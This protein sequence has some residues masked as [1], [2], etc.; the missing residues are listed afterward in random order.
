[1]KLLVDN[2]T[3]ILNN[4]YFQTLCLL[5]YPGEKFPTLSDDSSN[6]AFFKLEE[7][8]SDNII[9]YMATVRL[10]AGLRYREAQF[11]SLDY[12]AVIDGDNEFFATLALGKAFLEAGK[13]L[14]GFSMPWGYIIGLRPVKRARYYLEHGYDADTVKRF[15]IDDYGVLEQK[16]ELSVNT[17]LLEIQMLSGVKNNTCGLYISIPFCPTRCSYC[18]FVSY[19]N[20]KLFQLIPDYLEKLKRDLK[21]T[22]ALLKELNFSLGT[23]Y[24]GGGTPSILDC[25]QLEDLLGTV[26]KSFNLNNLKEYSFEAGRPDTITADKLTVIKSHGVNRISI[27]PQTTNENVLQRI[28]RCHTVSQFFNSAELAKKIGFNCI[29]ADLIAGLPDDT[30]ENFAKSLSD[31][32]SLNFENITVHTLSIKNAA[33]LRFDPDKLYDPA[34]ETARN[35]VAYAYDKLIKQGYNPYYLYRQ[36]NTVGNAE[37]T[38]YS[39]AGYESLYNVLMMEEYSSIFACGAGAITKII[40]KNGDN[41]HIERIAFPKYPFEYLEKDSDIGKDKIREFFKG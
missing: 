29:N 10:E 41:E 39:K 33:E 11:S 34:G 27:N 19:S 7:V 15:F 2:K 3:G 23:I 26:E 16:A 24:V 1:M 30:E 14:F 12:K 31:V 5:Y 37:N 38:G 21:Q 13:K 25:N 6:A 20:K 28:G 35:C 18:S 32:I 4:Y 36:K 8:K 9:Y 40:K 17:A 22:A